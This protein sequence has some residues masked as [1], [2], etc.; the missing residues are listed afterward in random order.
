MELTLERALWM[1]C[2]WLDR[3]D[4]LLSRH[5]F[6]TSI[7]SK[8]VLVNLVSFKDFLRLV[9]CLLISLRSFPLFL[10]GWKISVL[11]SCCRIV[12]VV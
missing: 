9:S 5:L 6:T 2:R 8:R 3:F 1:V 12:V 4:S 7:I 11:K 10:S